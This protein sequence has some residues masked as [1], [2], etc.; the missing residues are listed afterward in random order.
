MAGKHQPCTRKH[1]GHC[2][3]SALILHN[4]KVTITEDKTN[5]LIKA[6]DINVELFWSGLFA[7]VLANVNIRSLI[8]NVRAGGLALAADAVP[9]EGPAPTAAAA[10]EKKVEAKKLESEESDDNM[11]FRLS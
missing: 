11:G 8:C 9:A 4:D 3:Y 2:L 7:K 6:A 5:T 10:A 1:H